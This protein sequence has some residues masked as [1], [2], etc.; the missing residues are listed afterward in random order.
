MSTGQ[1]IGHSSQLELQ[2][3]SVYTA[4]NG[5]VSG[6]FGSQKRDALDTTD[7][8]TTGTTRTF[9][10]GLENPGEWSGKFN[11][12]PGDVTQNDL[13]AADDGAIHS[14]KFIYPNGTNM[15]VFSGIVLSSK[16]ISAPDDKL[17][18]FSVKIQLTGASTDTL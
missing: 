6:D 16:D 7:A 4:I 17:V 12:L 14:F 18:T 1:T 3:G 2:V 5:L 10:G 11:Y 13:W 15:R 8:G 9:I